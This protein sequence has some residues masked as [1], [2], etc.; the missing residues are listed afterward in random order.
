MTLSTRLREGERNVV[1]VRRSIVVCPVTIDAI[2]RKRCILI[3]RVADVARNCQV[4]SRERES[5]SAVRECRRFPYCRCV[6]CPTSVT[7]CTGDVIWICRNRKI[8]RMALVAS[9]V[10]Q[11]VVAID[12]ARLARCCYVGSREGKLC[13]TMVEGRRFPHIRRMARLAPMIQHSR[14]VVWIRWSGIICGMAWIAVGVHKLIV[15]VYVTRLTRRCRVQAGQRELRRTVIEGRRLP[16]VHRM[17]RL[18]ETAESTGHV[19]WIRWR[20][21]IC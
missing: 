18:A 11:L 7:E 15:A 9:G 8:R 20:D 3:A 5:D 6:A 19:I 4:S 12:V 10:R 21:K 16:H 1:R 17:A 14:N 2:R 13:R